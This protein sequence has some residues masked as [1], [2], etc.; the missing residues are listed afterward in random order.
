MSR[1]KSI[2]GQTF[3]EFID[4]AKSVDERLRLLPLFGSVCETVAVM[5]ERGSVCGNLQAAGII[6]GDRGEIA[7]LDYKELAPDSAYA[8]PEVKSGVA[9]ADAASDVYSLGT[10]LFE[11]LTGRRPEEMPKPLGALEASP[12]EYAD[13]CLHSVNHDPAA[14]YSSARQL[15]DDVHSLR[16][17][18][19]TP[20]KQPSRDDVLKYK[21]LFAA[22]VTAFIVALI[23][24]VFAYRNATSK[25]DVAVAALSAEKDAM[26]ISRQEAKQELSRMQTRL[27]QTEMSMEQSEGARI[28]AE[29]ARLAAEN[30]LAEA[31]SALSPATGA[32][33]ASEA[34]RAQPE[35]FKPTFAAA[36]P[37][38]VP[39]VATQAAPAPS[40]TA[41]PKPKPA[42]PTTPAPEPKPQPEP[43][44]KPVPPQTPAPEPAPEPAQPAGKAEPPIRPAGVTRA[45]FAHACPALLASLKEE[46]SDG[47][48]ALVIRVTDE[49]TGA[50][51]QK[52]GLKDGDVISRI[53]RN[54][55][56]NVDQASQ[57]LASVANDAGFSVR[58]TRGG[59]SG[60][61]RVNF[62]DA[63]PQP[64]ARETPKEQ[65]ATQPAPVQQEAQDVPAEPDPAEA[66]PDAQDAQE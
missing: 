38:S 62:S 59:Q 43:E 56:Q 7:I 22:A 6:V 34:E 24:G 31:K 58:I 26:D 46:P 53:N 52:L 51:I 65:P 29:N 15:A 44:P 42:A 33:P 20:D 49:A 14:R 19:R 63:K 61:I 28:A 37:E 66:A 50:E 60:W 16:L 57:A 55:I 10:I 2:S 23:M 12:A 32:A 39:A 40:A 27:K 41:A 13:I 3:R 48:T 25:L 21:A 8:A 35:E 9:E 11:I 64:P 4:G 17:G 36:L 1:K 54:S 5:H 47:T 45:E 18:R 30:A